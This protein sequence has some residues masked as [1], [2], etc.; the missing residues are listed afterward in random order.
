MIK[1]QEIQE[2]L[3]I[4]NK[5][6]DFK[7]W[8]NNNEGF[9]LVHMFLM[10]DQN[11]QLGFYNKKTD[12]IVAINITDKIE[13]LPAEDVFKSKGTIEQLDLTD[14]KITCKNALEQAYQLQKEKYPAQKIAREMVILQVL[15]QP[16]FNI[17]LITQAFA[18]LNIRIDAISGDLISHKLKSIMDLGEFK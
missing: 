11:P 1:I 12:K 16:V 10:T 18:T 13:I 8:E 2:L 7:N 3:E 5:S 4:L 9:Y 6:E 17:T 15:D 14:I